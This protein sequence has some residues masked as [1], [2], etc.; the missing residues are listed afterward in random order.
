M[1]QIEQAIL[2]LTKQVAELIECQKKTDKQISQLS[3]Y[4]Q[5]QDR[6]LELSMACALKQYF[7][8]Q[9]DIPEDFIAVFQRQ[10]IY[11]ASSGLPAVEWDSILMINYDQDTE[12]QPNW[13]PS[14]SFYFLESKQNLNLSQVLESV[15]LKINRTVDAIY[16]KERSKKGKIIRLVSYQQCFFE[17]SL[18]NATINIVIGS[19][20]IDEAKSFLMKSISHL[21]PAGMSSK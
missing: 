21:C 3:N 1:D 6:N 16:S 5:N 9:L 20:N 7:V 15:K 8:K 17:S 10:P 11:N 4:N 14:P 13:P 18:K 2:D 19:R 12:L